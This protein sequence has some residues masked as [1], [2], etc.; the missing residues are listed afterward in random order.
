[1]IKATFE[2]YFRHCELN[3]ITKIPGKC[4]SLSHQEKITETVLW[5]PVGRS[6]ELKG[7]LK[8][9]PHVESLIIFFP[10]K[11]VRVFCKKERRIVQVAPLL[12]RLIRALVVPTVLTTVKYWWQPQKLITLI[13]LSVNC[14]SNNN[15]QLMSSKFFPESWQ[16][17][18]AQMWRK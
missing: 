18:S 10:S 3:E 11:C 2:Y 4:S 1:M 6:M 7:R 14:S 13:L 5:A 8:I 9:W 12:S 15:S 16:Y 17:C